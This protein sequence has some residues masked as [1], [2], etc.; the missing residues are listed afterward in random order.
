MGVVYQAY[1]QHVASQVRTFFS[2]LNPLP[3]FS[4][5]AV[6]PLKLPAEAAQQEDVFRTQNLGELNP[7]C[8]KNPT[9][10]ASQM[11][12]PSSHNPPVQDVVAINAGIVPLVREVS[13]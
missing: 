13:L 3:R 6:Q 7:L 2:W 5:W 1:A 4:F 10:Q 9:S 12:L 11:P 8:Q